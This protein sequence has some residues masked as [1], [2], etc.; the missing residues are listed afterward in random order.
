MKTTLISVH[1]DTSIE[2][3]IH[4]MTENHIKRMPVIDE[5][6]VFKGSISRDSVLR[7]GMGVPGGD[8]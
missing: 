4:L 1:E 8:S 3:A 5:N 2:D 7:A 6:G